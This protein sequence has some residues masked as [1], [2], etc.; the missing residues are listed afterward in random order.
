M[1]NVINLISTK[2]LYGFTLQAVS[3]LVPIVAQADDRP[4]ILWIVSEDNTLESGKIY[5]GI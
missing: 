2:K 1:K 4:N 3:A 5:F